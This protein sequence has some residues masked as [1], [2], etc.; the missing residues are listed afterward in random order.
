MT[1]TSLFALMMDMEMIES[2]EQ[3]VHYQCEVVV[4]QKNDEMVG[5]YET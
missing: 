3:M 5:C 4:E 1:K 2:G